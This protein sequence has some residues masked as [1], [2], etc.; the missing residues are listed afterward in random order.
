MW[1][2]CPR[3]PEKN[4]MNV[5]TLNCPNCGAGVAS[6][7]SVCEFCKTRLKTVACPNCLDLMFE[8][9]KFCDHCGAPAV[10]ATVSD[11]ADLGVCPRCKVGL[12]Q[13]QIDAI[14]LRQCEK[15]D[16]LWSDVATFEKI[17]SS[18]EEQ[19]AALTFFGSRPLTAGLPSLIRYVP[20]PSC[21]Q[22]MNRSNFARSSGVIIDLCKEHGV[23]FDAG[24][25]P[26]I[27]E[28]IESGGL[29]RAREKERISIDDE[30]EKVR[31]E[32]RQL[33]MYEMRSSSYP[34]R[35]GGFES[36]GSDFIKAL[37]DL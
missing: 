26:K 25:L 15:C 16:G 13:L 7:S 33:E 19:T 11:S 18:K 31:E 35:A 9:S 34:Q 3:L 10:A 21:G 28:F 8:G 37:F 20:C 14:S 32:R 24:E 12:K 6:D 2:Q 23:W 4:S 30:R 29:A 27:I 17:C 5:K 1:A 22:L 36:A